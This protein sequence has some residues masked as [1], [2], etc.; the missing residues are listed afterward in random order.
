MAKIHINI[1]SNKGDRAALIERA[2]ALLVNRLDPQ[3]RGEARL[4]GIIESEP[5]GFKSPNS[6]FNLGIML[7]LPEESVDPHTILEALQAVEREMST[8][9]H[10]KPDGSYADREIDIDLIAVD[11]IVVD[12]A[13]LTLPHPRMSQRSFVLKPVAEL[14]PEWHHPITGLSAMDMLRQL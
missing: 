14:D 1:G 12:D 7:D 10:R 2:V 8:D 3:N 9:S 5:W 4:A 11:D 6:F 13:A